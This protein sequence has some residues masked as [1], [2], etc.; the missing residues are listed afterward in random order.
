MSTNSATAASTV[1][2][3][4]VFICRI[5]VWSSR[6]MICNCSPVLTLFVRTVT[7]MIAPSLPLPRHFCLLGLPAVCWLQPCFWPSRPHVAA[8]HRRAPPL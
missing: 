6:S 1:S 8:G 2:K 3:I 5:C 7:M 4:A